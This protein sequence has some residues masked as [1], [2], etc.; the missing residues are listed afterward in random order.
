MKKECPVFET[1]DAKSVP[2]CFKCPGEDLENVRPSGFPPGL[3]EFRGD[4]PSCRMTTWLDFAPKGY[5]RSES[6]PEPNDCHVCGGGGS[7]E[8]GRL[9]DECPVCDG[10]GIES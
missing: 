2:S 4:C 6:K 5:G 8:D 7:L 10:T 1:A 3:G 9:E